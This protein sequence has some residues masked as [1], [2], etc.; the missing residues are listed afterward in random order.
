VERK[1]TGESKAGLKTSQ[2]LEGDREGE[3]DD[4][5]LQPRHAQDGRL[6]RRNV[7]SGQEVRGNKLTGLLAQDK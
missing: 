3:E 6:N 4:T 2:E 5:G 7:L 1:F